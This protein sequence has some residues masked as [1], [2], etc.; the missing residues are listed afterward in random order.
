MPLLGIIIGGIDFTS[1]S[2]KVNDSVVMYGMFVITSY[3]IHYTKLYDTI[4]CDIADEESVTEMVNT[5]ITTFGKIDILVNNAGIAIDTLVADKTV[6]DFRRTLDVNLIGTFIV[7][8]LVAD[9]MLKNGG[10]KI[11]NRNNFV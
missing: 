7:S 6:K 3:S 10:G 11:I 9:S 2:F 4:K 1:L 5:V 8:R